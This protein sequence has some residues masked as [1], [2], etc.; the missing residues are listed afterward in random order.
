MCPE[1]TPTF[2]PDFGVTITYSL[3]P[4]MRFDFTSA[5]YSPCEGESIGTIGRRTRFCELIAGELVWSGE[6]PECRRTLLYNY[7]TIIMSPIINMQF[8][9]ATPAN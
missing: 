3:G 1:L 4:N 7:L 9:F 6:E 5:Q 2:G 8:Y